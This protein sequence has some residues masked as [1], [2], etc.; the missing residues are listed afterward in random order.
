MPPFDDTSFELISAYLDGELS[1]EERAQVESLLESSDEHRQLL[2]ELQSLR[3]QFESIPKQRAPERLSSR[4]MDAIA[5][6]PVHQPQVDTSRGL[7]VL[8][9]GSF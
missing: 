2:D 5:D 6:Q 7:M 4:I 1:V 9:P 8:E 3:V